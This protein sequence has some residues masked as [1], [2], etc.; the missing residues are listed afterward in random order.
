MMD[1]LTLTELCNAQKTNLV[2]QRYF[3]VLAHCRIAPVVQCTVG[4]ER[5]V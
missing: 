2:G 5:Q 3:Y 4:K 1:D